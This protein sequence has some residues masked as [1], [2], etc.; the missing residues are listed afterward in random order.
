MGKSGQSAKAREHLSI[1]PQLTNRELSKIDFSPLRWSDPAEQ[2][3][4]LDYCAQAGMLIREWDLLPGETDFLEGDT[5]HM[6]WA[7][8]S[9]CIGI[10]SRLAEQAVLHA[11]ERSGDRVLREDLAS[12]VDTRG[13]PNGMCTYNPF[14]SGVRDGE[15]DKG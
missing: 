7:A 1:D 12:A 11:I 4:F 15:I 10:V 6:L 2:G 13:I 5:P 8:S 14:R 9:G 3:I